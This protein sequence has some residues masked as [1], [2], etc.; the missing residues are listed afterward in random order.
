MN[1]KTVPGRRG[2]QFN[3]GFGGSKQI[4]GPFVTVEEVLIISRKKFS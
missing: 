2:F 3:L 4:D 1:A